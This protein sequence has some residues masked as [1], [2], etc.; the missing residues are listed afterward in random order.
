MAPI[1]LAANRKAIGMNSPVA[2]SKPRRKEDLAYQVLTVVAMVS[3]LASVWI[4]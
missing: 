3:L 4:F 1:S 2:V